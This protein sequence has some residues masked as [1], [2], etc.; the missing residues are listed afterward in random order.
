[1]PQETADSHGTGNGIRI[2]IDQNQYGVIARKL[3][4]K[5]PQSF[6]RGNWHGLSVSLDRR[7]AR[8]IR[9]PRLDYNKNIDFGHSVTAG[10]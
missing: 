2:R 7:R 10:V 8:I 1:V 4:V 9:R 3:V 6:G 5:T